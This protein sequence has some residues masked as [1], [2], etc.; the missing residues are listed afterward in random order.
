MRHIANQQKRK[1]RRW[2]T[3]LGILLRGTSPLLWLSIILFAVALVWIQGIEERRSQT[4]RFVTLRSDSFEVKSGDCLELELDT[5][6]QE[7]R[8]VC[9]ANVVSIPVHTTP[10]SVQADALAQAELLRTLEGY[11]VEFDSQNSTT[12]PASNERTRLFRIALDDSEGTREDLAPILLESG[13]VVVSA[14]GDTAAPE[15]YWN[16]EAKARATKQGIWALD[17]AATAIEVW[18]SLPA[19]T[20]RRTD[21]G[22]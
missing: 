4:P 14:S 13:V 15:S 1:R 7:R 17:G 9:L 21:V 3:R 2:T 19:W 8:S 16:A 12:V 11:A 18:R 20:E 10:W 22:S 5:E 6:K